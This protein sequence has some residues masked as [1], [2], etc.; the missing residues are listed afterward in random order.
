MDVAKPTVAAGIPRPPVKTKGRDRESS[1]VGRGVE[2]KSDQIFVKAPRWK[3]KKAPVIRVKITFL[4]QMRLKGNL[5]A[6]GRVIDLGSK[7]SR[8]SVEVSR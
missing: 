4:V 8:L 7:L 6:V 2:R 1:E 3:S 5:F